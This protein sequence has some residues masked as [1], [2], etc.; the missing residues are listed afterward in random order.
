MRT[1]WCGTTCL[2]GRS[3]LTRI[4]CSYMPAGAFLIL[5]TKDWRLDTIRKASRQAWDIVPD[6]QHKV[7]INPLEQAR[8]CAIQVVRALERDPL[9]VQEDAPHKGKLAF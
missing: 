3:R 2:S 4:S 5:E 6:G 8:H 1:T 7:A 9:L